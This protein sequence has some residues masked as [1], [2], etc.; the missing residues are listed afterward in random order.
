MS[1]CLN[2]RMSA[3]LQCWLACEAEL[4]HGMERAKVKGKG[5]D[6]AD[7]PDEPDE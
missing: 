6:E 5:R 2:V 3:Y 7:E 1:E 4:R